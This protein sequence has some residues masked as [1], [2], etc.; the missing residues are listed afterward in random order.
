MRER[1]EVHLETPSCAGCHALT[2]PIGLGLERFDGLGGFRA[3]ENDVPIDP[4]GELDGASFDDARELG[5][6]LA[7][8]PAF[9]P[10]VVDTLWAY[11]N[12]QVGHS[13]E[14]TDVL[15]AGFQAKGYRLLELLR[16]IA[17][18]EAF[19]HVGPDDE[20]EGP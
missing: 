3:T 19:R 13:G 15:V 14:Q 17:L 7:D 18:S 9:V 11:A 2:D 10:C 5:Q 16:A 8:H 1:L 6:V 20:T 4:S 12:G